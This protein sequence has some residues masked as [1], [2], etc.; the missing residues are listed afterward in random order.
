M[1][2][3]GHEGQHLEFKSSFLVS[4]GNQSEDQQFVVFKAACAMMNA[5]GGV[6]LIGVDDKTSMPCRGKYYGVQGDKLR[7]HKKTMTNMPDI[8]T[9]KLKNILKMINMSEESCGRRR[10]MMMLLFAL[11]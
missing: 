6:I 11:M 4:A 9:A 10:L 2:L 1:K 3:Y 7:L 5:D 8:L